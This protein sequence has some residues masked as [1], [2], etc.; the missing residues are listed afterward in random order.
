MSLFGGCISFFFGS[1]GFFG[2]AADR[3]PLNGQQITNKIFVIIFN[4]FKLLRN[5]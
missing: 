2:S 3:L 5:K 4:S 1:D